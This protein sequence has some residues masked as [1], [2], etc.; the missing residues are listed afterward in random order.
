MILN[1]CCLIDN[2]WK[3]IVLENTRT[4]EAWG[5]KTVPSANMFSCGYQCQPVLQYRFSHGQNRKWN[6]DVLDG[7]NE[8]FCYI[9]GAKEF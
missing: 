2:L 9:K 5:R 1:I 4:E 8:K 7:N 6:K 3:G